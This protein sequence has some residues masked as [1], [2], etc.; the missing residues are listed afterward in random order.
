MRRSKNL[1]V[2]KSLCNFL[3][4]RS[5]QCKHHRNQNDS[6]HEQWIHLSKDTDSIH[7]TVSSYFQSFNY[8]LVGGKMIWR[9]PYFSINPKAISSVRVFKFRIPWQIARDGQ[10]LIPSF[11]AA[12]RMSARRLGVHQQ[13]QENGTT[14]QI[15]PYK[16]FEDNHRYISSPQVIIINLS[17]LLVATLF[18]VICSFQRKHHHHRRPLTPICR[19]SFVLW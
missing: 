15:A 16:P 10:A 5:D 6:D 9:T 19:K 13:R 1:V 3:Y 2:L 11:A 12:T 18:P 14:G 8:V 4:F 7:A 17:F